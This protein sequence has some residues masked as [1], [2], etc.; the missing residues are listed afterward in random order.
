MNA[1]CNASKISFYLSHFIDKDQK[2]N[3]SGATFCI[4]CDVVTFL[5]Y[6]SASFVFYPFGIF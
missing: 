6:M 3:R 4:F 5:L 2:E 1:R